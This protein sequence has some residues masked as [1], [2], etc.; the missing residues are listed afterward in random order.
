MVPSTFPVDKS[1][2]SPSV[3]DCMELEM[4]LGVVAWMYSPN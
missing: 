4:T 3:L 1:A 2:M